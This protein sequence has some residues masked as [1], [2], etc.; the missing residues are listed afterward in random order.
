MKL[1]VPDF[2]SP[3]YFPA[4]AAAEL[5]LFKQEGLD[6]TIELITPVDRCYE[7]LRDEKVEF[8][9]GSAHSVPSAFP[10]WQGAKLIAALSQGMYWFLVMRADIG[11]K[12]GDI[13]AVKGR[14]IGAARM[15]ELGL[16]GLLIAA[17]IDLV[18]DQVTIAPVP[19]ATN[20]GVNFGLN[21]AK[22]LEDGKIDGF[23][24][25]GM[26]AEVA[27]RRG[28]GTMVLDV[29]RGEGPKEAFFYTMPALV[30][31]DALIGRSPKLAAGAARAIV[32]TLK[33]LKRDVGLA[34]QVG[35]KVFPAEEA[36][37]IA[38]LI[39][40]DLPYYDA[41]I[42]P[43]FFERMQKFTQDMRL[44]RQPA[45]YNQAVAS[46]FSELWNA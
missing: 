9:G 3:S 41:A 45:R 32:G 24:A 18:R 28:V 6:V 42:S 26:G 31:S 35:R 14:R 39:T 4:I 23:W 40:R 29:R 1:A 22:A 15:V 21:A 33:A 37:L 17:G 16:K 7:A 12:R 44:V 10:D 2:I 19:G 13:S 11:A 25:N 36:E 30:T 43:E 27:I 8:V 34:T 20:P 38:G 46:Q 5:G